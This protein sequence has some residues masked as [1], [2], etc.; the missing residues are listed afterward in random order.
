MLISRRL[1]WLLCLLPLL[2]AAC[3]GGSKPTPQQLSGDFTAAYNQAAVRPGPGHFKAGFIQA[4]IVVLEQ[5]SATAALVAG[6][7]FKE[8]VH[9]AIRLGTRATNCAFAHY[10]FGNLI[11]VPSEAVYS[12]RYRGGIVK[13]VTFTNQGGYLVADVPLLTGQAG[14]EFPLLLVDAA[15]YDDPILTI[16]I[17]DGQG[18]EVP[19]SYLPGKD[20]R[21][22]RIN[23]V[24]TTPR[25]R[26]LGQGNDFTDNQSGGIDM[27]AIVPPGSCS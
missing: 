9:P 15:K 19:L 12:V 10:S 20:T 27:V 6:K 22:N 18:R 26:A 7:S 25:N 1:V 16:R 24:V 21:P 3:V 17:F 14:V 13:P 5:D 4:T 2:L 23:A 8:Y 11:T